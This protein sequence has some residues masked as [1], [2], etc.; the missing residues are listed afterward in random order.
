M[1]HGWPLDVMVVEGHAVLPVGVLLRV[2]S[3]SA[4]D[5]QY[6][7]SLGIVETLF[8]AYDLACRHLP[9]RSD[10]QEDAQN[11]WKIFISVRVEACECTAFLGKSCGP[12]PEFVRPW[13]GTCCAR[14]RAVPRPVSLSAWPS[15]RV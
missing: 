11:K 15:F 14:A 6:D 5:S 4:Q 9:E 3:T 7:Y 1:N 2:P 10:E 12:D 8:L 13:H